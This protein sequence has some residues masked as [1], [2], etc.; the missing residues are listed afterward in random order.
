[1][2]RDLPIEVFE[3]SPI[4]HSTLSVTARTKLERRKRGRKREGGKREK[5]EGGEREKEER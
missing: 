2:F 5:K 4:C 1:M 3:V